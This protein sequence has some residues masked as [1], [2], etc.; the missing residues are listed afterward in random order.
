MSRAIADQ[1]EEFAFFQALLKATIYAHIPLTDRFDADAERIRFVQFHRP[2][3]GQLVLP[4]FT[5]EKKA[6][7]AAQSAVQVVAMNGRLFLELARRA[8]LMMDP[9]DCRCVL[10]PEEIEQLLRT[11]HIATIHKFTI[12]ERTKSR[13][14]PPQESPAWLIDA[15]IS[16][17][18]KLSFVQ[19][20]YLAGVYANADTTEQTGLIIALDGEKAYAERT[21]HAVATVAQ[22]LC[23]AHNS[24][25]L[26]LTHFDAK[27]GVPSWITDL[28]LEPFYERDWGAR[29]Y[30][31]PE[32]DTIPSA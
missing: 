16:A 20:A 12:Q 25:P 11:G 18:A 4:F 10:Y 32:A 15:L 13:V 7:V 21:A 28:A 23:E 19:R 27:V 14:G 17:L 5:D 30:Q 2:D 1:R 29:L 24:L 26:D 22:P 8:T 31:G 9:N 6:R 3:T